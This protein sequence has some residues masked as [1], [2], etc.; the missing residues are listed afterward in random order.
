MGNLGKQTEVCSLKGG[1]VTSP[2]M[3]ICIVCNVSFILPVT[4][5]GFLLP[6][7]ECLLLPGVECDDWW[8]TPRQCADW[9][10]TH[11]TL[12]TNGKN[13]YQSNCGPIQPV[14]SV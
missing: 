5:E 7:V 2:S 3:Y 9:W 12:L 13:P 8:G 10:G 6:G 11:T 1:G 4:P 14:L